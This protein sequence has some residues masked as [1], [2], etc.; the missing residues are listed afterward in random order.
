MNEENKI[1]LKNRKKFGRFLVRFRNES[2]KFTI[3]SVGTSHH[4]STDNEYGIKSQL[5]ERRDSYHKFWSDPY[6]NMCQN[7]TDYS[8][9]LTNKNQNVFTKV[10]Q[11]KS[12][13]EEMII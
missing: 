1:I 8:T 11:C 4:S 5:A 9:T 3:Q 6:I 13:N 10:F 2:N 7:P 12:L